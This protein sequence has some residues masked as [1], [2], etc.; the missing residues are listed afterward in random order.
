M[1]AIGGLSLHHQLIAGAAVVAVATASP[2][3]AQ[4]RS[5]NVPPEA[6]SRGIPE[7]A[8]QAGVQI[9]ASGNVVAGRKTNAVHG[10]Y[11]VEEGL[12]ILLQGTGLATARA[13]G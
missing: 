3:Q 5:F 12:R 11:T 1:G 4:S 8:K 10:S 9:L 13:D 2:A 7:F 6:A